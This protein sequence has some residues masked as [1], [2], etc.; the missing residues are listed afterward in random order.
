MS[1]PLTKDLSIKNLQTWKKKESEFALCFRHLIAIEK[2]K[3]L[4][5]EVS[6]PQLDDPLILPLELLVAPLRKRFRYH[7]YGD[8]KTNAKH[9]V[10]LDTYM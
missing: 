6:I 8:K 7:F 9:K 2:I 3:Y 5:S 4:S 1:W 10:S